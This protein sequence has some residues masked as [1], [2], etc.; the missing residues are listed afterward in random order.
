[1]LS[2]CWRVPLLV[3][4]AG[5]FAERRSALCASRISCSAG[6]IGTVRSDASVFTRD[7][8]VSRAARSRSGR[9][10]RESSRILGPASTRVATTGRRP[11]SRG[12]LRPDLP[13]ADAADE[14]VGVRFDVAM[15]RPGGWSALFSNAFRH[16]RN[17]MVLLDDSR[18]HVDANGAYLNLL[19]YARKALIGQP[20]YRSEARSGSSGRPGR[21]YESARRTSI[22]PSRARASKR[23]CGKTA[24]PPFTSPLQTSNR[25]PCQG[26]TTMSPSRSPSASGP[27]K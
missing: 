3:T 24:G 17:A 2:G 11:A 25:E 9:S 5:P 15:A 7:I 12:R 21:A 10:S 6:S 23:G 16:S 20:I 27:P 26:Q 22:F 8:R 1:M 19:G 4:K 14:R 18:R 13:A